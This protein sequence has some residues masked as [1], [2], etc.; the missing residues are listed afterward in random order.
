MKNKILST[1]LCFFSLLFT[2]CSCSPSD[3]TADPAAPVDSS[4]SATETTVVTAPPEPPH[5]IIPLVDKAAEETEL[6][7]LDRDAAYTVTIA[8]NP[9]SYI[10][11]MSIA[12][13][14]YFDGD[15]ICVPTGNYMSTGKVGT[16]IL[17]YDTTGC[18]VS[19]TPI[20]FIDEVPVIRER[21]L[22]DET[23][24]YYT[25][26]DFNYTATKIFICDTDGTVLHETPLSTYPNSILGLD[27]TKNFDLHI[28]TRSDGTLRILVNAYDKLYYLDESLNILNTVAL[29]TPIAYMYQESDGVY[30]L[31]DRLPGMARVN[32]E[33]GELTAVDSLPVPDGLPDNTIYSFGTD[34]SLYYNDGDAF[35]R[36]V[37]DGTAEKLFSWA[38]GRYSGIGPFWV[39]DK[40]S[41]FYIQRA[42]LDELYDLYPL[43]L[44]S[45]NTDETKDSRRVIDC[46]SFIQNNRWIEETV[47]LFNSQNSDYYLRITD[48]NADLAEGEKAIDRLSDM[49]IKGDIPD[50]VLFG[51]DN[52]TKNFTDKNLFVDL[53][54]HYGDTLLG[55]ASNAYTDAH[56]YQYLLPISMPNVSFYAA[57]ADVCDVPLTW[58]KLYELGRAIDSDSSDIR[59]ITSY[60]NP[61]QLRRDILQAFVDER[62]AAVR[63]D[64][65]EFRTRIRFAELLETQY[66][67]SAIGYMSYG[68]QSNLDYGIVE[69]T[70]IIDALQ[71]GEVAL[72]HVPFH[73]LDGYG[74][75]KLIFGDTPFTLCGNPTDDGAAPHVS[76]STGT[77]RLAL[78]SDSD[79]L[80]GCKAFLDFILSDEI[81]SS[82]FMTD[83]A[84]PVTYTGLQKALENYRYIYYPDPP[85]TLD[86]DVFGQPCFSLL[87]ADVAHSANSAALRNTME[88]VLSDADM[89]TIL[90]F[91]ATCTAAAGVDDTINDIAAEELSAYES[92]AKTLE[93]VTRLMQSRVQI[94]LNE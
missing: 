56:G 27:S 45:P 3:E 4:A 73:S 48:L 53:A 2:I 39:I 24:V 80:G 36:A 66:T 81:Q 50:M 87:L 89:E 15:C 71:S 52:Q 90:Q 54:P 37:G 59:A 91:F 88:V 25:A 31:G 55:Y 40:T 67:D 23:F 82:T 46:A 79:V 38:D 94:Y 18:C 17:R 77:P 70:A 20:P 32:M 64:S 51:A 30:I 22:S 12:S 76:V 68:M 63:F 19:E 16:T 14:I 84:L 83:T 8:E 13:K 74:A 11:S 9:D 6:E 60:L 29:P 5:P 33:T 65:E 47:T 49:L 26:T 35:Y 61:T 75:L 86:Q 10:L 28:D 85:S 57:A 1:F 69:N 78:C 43:A 42:Q 21:P 58:D 72:L 62:T 93:E 7:I 92:G 44:L 34:G 41:V